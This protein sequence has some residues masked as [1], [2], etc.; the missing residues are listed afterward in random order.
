MEVYTLDFEKYLA[1]NGSLEFKPE[2]TCYWRDPF[3]H[4]TLSSSIAGGLVFTEEAPVVLCCLDWRTKVAECILISAQGY[5]QF[6]AIEDYSKDVPFNLMRLAELFHVNDWA[7]VIQYGSRDAV[8]RCLLVPMNVGHPTSPVTDHSA[9]SP[10]RIKAESTAIGVAENATRVEIGS[11]LGGHAKPTPSAFHDGGKVVFVEVD[12]Q[13]PAYNVSAVDFG[14]LTSSDPSTLGAGF[15][16]FPR[17]QIERICNITE[18]PKLGRS[19]QSFARSQGGNLSATPLLL[20]RLPFSYQGHQLKE[21]MAAVGVSMMH[22]SLVMMDD[23]AGVL[24]MKHDS[25]NVLTFYQLG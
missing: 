15:H 17:P 23:A 22:Q 6:S 25:T 7:G 12:Y 10:F 14:S 4:V 2:A 16:R 24:C 8:F 18:V 19:G 11:L 13:S 21:R 20:H 5:Y 9:F 3:T 1:Q